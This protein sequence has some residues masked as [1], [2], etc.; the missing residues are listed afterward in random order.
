MEFTMFPSDVVDANEN[1]LIHFFYHILNFDYRSGIF[2]D[3]S[4]IFDM[5]DNIL[6]KE[7]YANLRSQ[8]YTAS[9]DADL[10]YHQGQKLYY[11]F[12]SK[13]HEERIND[14]CMAVYGFRLDFNGDPHLLK[15]IVSVMKN[16]LPHKDWD[17]EN[18]FL[19][20]RMDIQAEKDRIA[21]DARTIELDRAI[22]APEFQDKEATN[23]IP[24]GRIRNPSKEEI[25]KGFNPFLIAK[26]L[27]M[28]MSEA[29]EVVKKNQLEYYKNKKFE[30]PEF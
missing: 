28:S 12:V 15:D 30:P 19:I 7:D 26:E 3:E 14:K 24:I 5:S 22:S 21:N 4:S 2:T 10:D 16:K 29:L 13:L 11:G 6:S 25:L 17:S 18:V 27:D 23:V 9:A 20:K 8:Y 1:I